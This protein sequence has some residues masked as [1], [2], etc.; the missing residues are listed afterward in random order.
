MGMNKKLA[1]L[2]SAKGLTQKELVEAL[3][4]SIQTISRCEVGTAAPSL[5]NMVRL[6]EI[7]WYLPG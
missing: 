3:H 4:V 2:R 1:E 5:D 6:N 7:I